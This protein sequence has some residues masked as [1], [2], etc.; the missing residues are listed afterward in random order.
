MLIETS[1]TYKSRLL[2]FLDIHGHSTRRNS[3]C[4]GPGI[5]DAQLFNDIRYFPKII[6]SKTEIFRYPSCSF[7]ISNDKKTTAR[8]LFSRFVGLSYTIESSNWSYYSKEAA[9]VIEFDAYKWSQVGF[10]LKQSIEEY[11]SQKVLA[12][13]TKKAKKMKELDQQTNYNQKSKD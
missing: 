2:L 10:F 11:V 1:K 8:A 4:F 6:A 7:R 3:F 13:Q 12:K 9:K 5:L